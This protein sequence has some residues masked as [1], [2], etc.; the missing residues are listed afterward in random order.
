M[1]HAPASDDPI[2]PANGKTTPDPESVGLAQRRL[3]YA[4]RCENLIEALQFLSAVLRK[5]PAAGNDTRDATARVLAERLPPEQLEVA[6]QRIDAMWA[7]WTRP[8]TGSDRNRKSVQRHARMALLAT[9]DHAAQFIHLSK[10][11]RALA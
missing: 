5:I 11:T 9:V 8:D 3:F 2:E 4:E 1:R 10:T 6:F 7:A